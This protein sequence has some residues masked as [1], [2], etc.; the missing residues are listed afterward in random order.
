MTLQHPVDL[1]PLVNDEDVLARVAKLVG[2]AITDR[3]LWLMLVD[4]D[5]RQTPVVVPIS[6]MPRNPDARGLAGLSRVLSGLRAELATARGPGAVIFTRERR[7][8]EEVSPLDRAWAAA[9]A[10]VCRTADVG[11][12]GVYLST[13]GGVARLL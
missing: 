6:G 7:G 12:R 9:L 5:G 10:E 4:G 8:S 13:P 3:Q 1:P 2:T 11:L